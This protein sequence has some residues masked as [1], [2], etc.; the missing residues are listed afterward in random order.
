MATEYS[1]GLQIVTKDQLCS[2]YVIKWFSETRSSVKEPKLQ[3]LEHRSL[4][5]FSDWAELFQINF[6]EIAS[7]HFQALFLYKMN[8]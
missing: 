7:V 8:L 5:D 1:T 6:C 2:E 4:S 3:V